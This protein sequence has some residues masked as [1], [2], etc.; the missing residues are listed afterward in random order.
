MTNDL[1]EQIANISKAGAYD[2]MAAYANE[3]KELL[4]NVSDWNNNGVQLCK[5]LP[6]DLAKKIKLKTL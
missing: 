3:L 5:G 1:F 2:I 6:E 4:K